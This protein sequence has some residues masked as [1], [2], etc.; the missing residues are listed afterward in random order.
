MEALSAKICSPGQ[1]AALRRSWWIKGQK[2]VFTNGVFDIV[3]KGHV[4]LL[5]QAASM[6]QRLIVGLNAD[7][8]VK[9]LGKGD[10]RPI[11]T[12]A[13]R[14]L[15]IAAMQV[16]DA[17]VIFES[18]TPYALIEL[19]TPDVLVKGGDYNTEQT[20]PSAKDYIVGSDLQRLGGR[21]TTVI[22]LVEGHS[23][24]SIIE[25]SSRG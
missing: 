12:E 22:P 10:N 8:S 21:E 7:I 16:V 4:T 11:H 9:T 17:V 18:S 24:T 5:A 1:A 23:T 6:G 3:H 20:D 14:A 13:D 19:L 2:V 15:V 25:K